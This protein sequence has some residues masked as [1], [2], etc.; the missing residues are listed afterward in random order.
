[1]VPC[2]PTAQSRLP[3]LVPEIEESTSI[4][5]TVLIVWLAVI[6]LKSTTELAWPRLIA[7][8]AVAMFFSQPVILVLASVGIAA[9]LDR[10]F[11][12]SGAWRKYCV[13][14]AA[15]WLTVFGLLLWFSY[16]SRPVVGDFPR[17]PYQGDD[18]RHPIFGWPLRD[19]KK[20]GWAHRAGRCRAVRSSAVSCSSAAVSNRD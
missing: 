3:S 18:S 20:I 1:M 16:R 2:L 7:V 13:T 19:Q 9:V 11:R 15:V 6:T 17:Y 8:G 4:L 14:A 5:V 12:S 10:R